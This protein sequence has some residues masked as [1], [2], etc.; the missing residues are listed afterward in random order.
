MKASQRDF[1]WKVK[2]KKSTPRPIRFQAQ[3]SSGGGGNGKCG[4]ARRRRK[5]DKQDVKKEEVA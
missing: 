4:A 1:S 2:T 3:C 5:N